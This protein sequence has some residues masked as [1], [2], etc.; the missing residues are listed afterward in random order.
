LAEE[1]GGQW[2]VLLAALEAERAA[3]VARGQRRRMPATAGSA[4]GDADG[5]TSAAQPS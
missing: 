4:P 2:A 5:E 3:R 1:K